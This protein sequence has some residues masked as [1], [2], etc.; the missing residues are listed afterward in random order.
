MSIRQAKEWFGGLPAKLKPKDREIA[1]RILKEIR[2]RLK[3][4]DDVGLEYLTLARTSAR[5]ASSTRSSRS[6]TFASPSSRSC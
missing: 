5:S 1:N 3:F 2:D 6:S 4:L